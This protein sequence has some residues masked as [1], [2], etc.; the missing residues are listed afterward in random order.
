MLVW[1]F[2]DGDIMGKKIDLDEYSANGNVED[3]CYSLISLLWVRN[4]L[5]I[6]DNSSTLLYLETVYHNSRLNKEM[7]RH[8]IDRHLKHQTESLEYLND[9]LDAAHASRGGKAI[10]HYGDVEDLIS[11]KI[12]HVTKI[13]NGLLKMR[14]D[15]GH[16]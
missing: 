5:N 12:R 14:D 11:S 4:E 6:P 10:S 1:A 2:M 13:S 3:M 8:A 9:V 15:L 16:H 7:M